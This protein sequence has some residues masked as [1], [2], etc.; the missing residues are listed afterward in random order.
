MGPP[1]FPADATEE[2]WT[3]SPKE[4]LLQNGHAR[5]LVA[6][7]ALRKLEKQICLALFFVFRLGQRIRIVIQTVNISY[8][9][10]SKGSR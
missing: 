2:I 4:L 8:D 9:Y 6:C 1:T 10:S 3:P 5:L 7:G